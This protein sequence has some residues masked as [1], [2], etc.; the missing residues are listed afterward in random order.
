MAPPGWLSTF[1]SVQRC[2][3]ATLQNPIVLFQFGFYTIFNSVFLQQQIYSFHIMIITCFWFLLNLSANL[4]K[5]I[6]FNKSGPRCQRRVR[7]FISFL[8]WFGFGWF[9]ISVSHFNFSIS[10]LVFLNLIFTCNFN[11]RDLV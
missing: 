11:K 1:V 7:L 9:S 2:R 8:V 4:R 6:E 3:L 5:N 10:F